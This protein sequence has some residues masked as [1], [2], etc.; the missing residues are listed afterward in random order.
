MTMGRVKLT[1]AAVLNMIFVPIAGSA[2]ELS[3]LSL[4]NECVDCDLSNRDLQRIDFSGTRL[5]NVDFSGSNLQGADFSRVQFTW[6][7]ISGANFRGANFADSAILLDNEFQDDVDFREVNLQS[8]FRGRTL[9]SPSGIVIIGQFRNS[10]LDGAN[11][12]GAK[13][14]LVGEGISARSTNFSGVSP[15]RHSMFDRTLDINDSDFEGADFSSSRL[16]RSRFINTNLKDTDFTD[17]ILMS[18]DFSGSDLSRAN[19]KG[20]I[21]I[22]SDLGDATMCGTIS[23]DGSL[24][25]IGC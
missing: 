1:V 19:F 20:A 12:T 13:V 2:D 21:L 3:M 17:S 9:G 23:P 22:D 24:L 14:E 15:R 5:K 18:V 6:G 8:S 11:F 16:E 7:K 10:K 4:T 25:Y